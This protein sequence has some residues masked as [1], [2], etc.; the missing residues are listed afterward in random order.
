MHFREW[1]S[2]L[3][4]IVFFINNYSSVK[5]FISERH[6][7]HSPWLAVCVLESASS[8][9]HKQMNLCLVKSY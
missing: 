1:L 9:Q 6:N 4:F 3:L 8:L 2:C 5:Y 7:S